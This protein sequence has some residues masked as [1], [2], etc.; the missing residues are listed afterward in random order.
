M[1]KRILHSY[2]IWS[3][4]NWHKILSY[5]WYESFIVECA[6]CKA[7]V[8]KHRSAILR[9]HRCKLC[10]RGN[11]A[12]DRHVS[13]LCWIL[14]VNE[15]AVRSRITRWMSVNR[16]LYYDSSRNVIESFRIEDRRYLYKHNEKYH[17][18]DKAIAEKAEL[19]F[20]NKKHEQ[21]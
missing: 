21:S 9:T 13:T 3:K 17:E 20:L 19:K 8:P 10:R 1:T 5:D 18:I 4:V 15:Y 2:A 12:T 14:W 6:T 7:I 11:S 16:A